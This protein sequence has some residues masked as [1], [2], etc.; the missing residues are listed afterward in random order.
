[1]RLQHQHP[2]RGLVHA[3]WLLHFQ[4]TWESNERWPECLGPLP[5]VWEIQM[6]PLLLAWPSPAVG[7][8]LRNESK[9]ENISLSLCNFVFQI[10]LLKALD[11]SV[12]TDRHFVKVSFISV[13]LNLSLLLLTKVDAPLVLCGLWTWDCPRLCAISVWRGSLNPLLTV[14]TTEA[15]FLGCASGPSLGSGI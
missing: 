3:P 6:R 14:G 12:S 10:N 2:I 9:M 11:V 4:C 1:M 5:P 15:G 13:A 7:S 8:Y